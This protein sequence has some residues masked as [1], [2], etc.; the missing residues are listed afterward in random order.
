MCILINKKMCSY[1]LL[2]I[3]YE[4]ELHCGDTIFSLML[5]FN[6][7]IPMFDISLLKNPITVIPLLPPEKLSK[8]LKI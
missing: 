2:P 7:K 4:P 6:F 8:N 3:T 5:Y 1:I